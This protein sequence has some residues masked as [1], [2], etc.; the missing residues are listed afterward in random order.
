MTHSKSKGQFPRF[1][2]GVIRFKNSHSL[3]AIAL[4]IG[5]SEADYSNRLK[6][7]FNTNQ[8]ESKLFVDDV[9]AFTKESG[10]YSMIDGLCK[11]VGLATPMPFNYNASANLNTEFLVATKALGDMAE[12]LNVNKLSANGVSRLSS[13][14]HSL[15]ASAMTIG[16]AAESRFGGVSIG[17]MFGDMA[18]GILS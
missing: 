9:I 1:Y 6:K 5:Y 15:V 16:Y 17:M 14:I 13:S 8:P 2:E 12:H 7:R 3:R 10:D 18:S 4:K 11:E